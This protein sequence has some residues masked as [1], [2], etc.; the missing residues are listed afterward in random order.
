MADYGVQ[1]YSTSGALLF[2]TVNAGRGTFQVSKG[3]ATS[4]VTT[5]T[6]KA[7]DLLLF[8]LPTVSSGNSFWVQKTTTLSGTGSTATFSVQFRILR[9]FGTQSISYVNYV[10]L[11]D[12]SQATSLATYG[13]R[14]WE[15]A[16]AYA[17][18]VSFDSRLFSSTAGEVKL[19]PNDV[20]TSA[21]SH[22][23]LWHSSQSSTRYY[24]AGPLDYSSVTNYVREYG[25]LFSNRTAGTTAYYSTV[26]GGTITGPGIFVCNKITS[27]VSSH[28]NSMFGSYAGTTYLG[29]Y[30]PQ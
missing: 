12:M 30:D 27:T 3:T 29:T 23:T 9:Q 17:G 5:I 14:C 20:Y 6:L 28:P 22:G 16:G 21:F 7:G 8:N 25:I 18:P 1:V 19:D 15:S 26:F 24:D 4:N 11:R 10:I 2:N 13:I